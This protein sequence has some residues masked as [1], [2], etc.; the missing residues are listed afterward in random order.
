M[1]ASWTSDPALGETAELTRLRTAKED[2]VLAAV[3]A[4]TVLS[5][6]MRDELVARGVPTEKIVIVPN[7][8]DPAAFEPATPDAALRRQYGLEDRW[9]F[10]YVSSMDHPREGHELLI[11]AAARLVRSG[12]PATC[13]IVGDGTRRSRAGG[14]GRRRPRR[15]PSCSPGACPTMPSVTTSPCSTRSSCRVSP[16]GPR[17]S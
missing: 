7:G 17:G 5:V 6:A 10:G 2:R 11:E 9:V 13:L 8:I 1:E 4:V 14:T 3:D 15:A 12:R 16:T